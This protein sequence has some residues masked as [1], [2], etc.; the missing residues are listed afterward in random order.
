LE[1]GNSHADGSGILFAA[2]AGYKFQFSSGFYM[3]TGGFLGASSGEITYSGTGNV[4]ND[5]TPFYGADFGL[6]F[7]F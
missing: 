5:T 7:A 2:N 4:W 3:R 1:D 6:G